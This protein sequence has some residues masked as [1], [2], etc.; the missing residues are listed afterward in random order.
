MSKPLQTLEAIE[1]E[2]LPA[3]KTHC[4]ACVVPLSNFNQLQKLVGK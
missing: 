2:L 1:P 3:M 4:L